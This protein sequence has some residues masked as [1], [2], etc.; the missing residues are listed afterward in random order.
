MKIITAFLLVSFAAFSACKK[1]ITQI[2]EVNQAF[3]AVYTIAP[4]DWKTTD[5]GI[6][7][8]VTF[9]IPELDDNIY[10][11]GAVLVYISFG[12]DYYEALPE[13]FDGITYGTIHSK[14]VVT[15]DL[16]ALDGSKITVPTQAVSA[17]IILIDAKP[18]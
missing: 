13:V 4:Q 7:Y 1:E 3:S 8:S 10:N 18:L 11:N 2:N 15:I 17:K 9:Q 5:N 12:S 14:G 6:N 16:S